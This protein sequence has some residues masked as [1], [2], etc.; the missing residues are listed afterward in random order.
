MHSYWLATP[1][2]FIVL[3]FGQAFGCAC[4]NKTTSD[5]TT[6]AF[7]AA[8]GW[9]ASLDDALRSAQSKNKPIAIYFAAKDE[10]SAIG[11]PPEAVQKF[12]AGNGNSVPTTV[13]DLPKLVTHLRAL[14]VAEFVKVT[15]DKTDALATKYQAQERWLILVAPNGERMDGGTILGRALEQRVTSAKAKIEAWQSS[16]Q[17]ASK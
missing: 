11:E 15:Y 6:F 7:P 2:L 14:G 16:T 8:V 9:A 13:F 17:A 1:V 10:S 3:S 5:A 4:Q 12:A